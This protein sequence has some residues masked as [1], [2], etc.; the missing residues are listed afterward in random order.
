M[1][2]EEQLGKALRN[3]HNA[4]DTA[5]A[6]KL[7]AEI[8]RVRAESIKTAQ[9]QTAP[10]EPPP[11]AAPSALDW[12]G[13]AARDANRKVLGALGG[14]PALA[15][16]AA[17]FIPR[18]ITEAATGEPIETYSNAFNRGLDELGFTEG[19]TQGQRLVGDV[20]GGVAA[21]LTGVG[22]GQQL[23]KSAGPVISGVGRTL[24]AAPATQVIAGG[25]AGGAAGLAREAG[26]GPGGQAVAGLAGGLAAPLAVPKRMGGVLGAEAAA[27][28]VADDIPEAEIV[29]Q[30]AT[31]QASAPYRQAVD[32][33]KKADIPLTTG[34]QTGQNWVKMTERTLAETPV[35]GTPLQRT[36]E[37]QQ[38]AYQRELLKR[39]GLD[40]GSDM[41]TPEA[42][43]RAGDAL[44]KRYSEALAGKEVSIADDD[45]LDA[46]GKIE[47]SHS[48]FVD[49]PAKARVRRIVGDFLDE[50]ANNGGKVSGEWYQAQRS[51]FAQRAMKNSEVADLYA[52]LKRALDQAFTRAAGDVKGGLDSQYARLQQ[53][54][55]ILD[56]NGGP[57]MSEG[58]VSPVQVA[59]TASGAPGGR[60]WQE[61][62]RAAA[63]VMPDRVGNSGTAQRNM[64]LGALGGGG[65]VLDPTS[66]IYGP[67]IAR[68]LSSGLARGRGNSLV[69]PGVDAQSLQRLGY[70]ASMAVLQQ[71]R[72]Q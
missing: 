11:A 17:T 56:R 44:S 39:V 30:S 46:L 57:A 37:N 38:R 28:A 20:A 32:E 65:A 25:G 72:S 23:A 12:V 29:R 49:D 55:G 71:Q 14:L 68:G 36:F 43:D 1:A 33:L 31:G 27:K 35:G 40:D 45:F 19:D 21:A 2:T 3:A 60:D 66:L 16:D 15:M 24:A 51:L 41:I 18:K 26:L 58:F 64:V 7:A 62:T 47:A 5:A 52:D 34:Q 67:L 61:F 69:N 22:A 8:K 54:R 50:A 13:G 70:P 59:R 42:L 53:L 4:G 9:A 63:A 48:R 10:A 6:S